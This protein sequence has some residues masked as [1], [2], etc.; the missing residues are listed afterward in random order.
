MAARDAYLNERFGPALSCPRAGF[1]DEKVCNSLDEGECAINPLARRAAGHRRAT[2]RCSS[3][4]ESS[5]SDDYDP[6]V[7]NS[8]RFVSV[9]RLA[10]SKRQLSAS[11]QMEMLKERWSR[12]TFER[13][14]R[15]FATRSGQ[16]CPTHDGAE[17][18]S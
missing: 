6:E 17:L 15:R 9:R 11:T 7:R 8:R 14:V 4:G 13:R 1:A 16:S 3:S 2:L 18:A 12:M 10:S 5:S